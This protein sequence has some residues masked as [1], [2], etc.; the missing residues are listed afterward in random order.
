MIYT[1]M[2]INQLHNN[3]KKASAFAIPLTKAG[4]KTTKKNI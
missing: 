3:L 2:N 1:Y 4:V